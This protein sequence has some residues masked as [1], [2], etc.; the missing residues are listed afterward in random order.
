MNC[1]FDTNIL[2]YTLGPIDDPRR[3]AARDLIVR[4]MR[5]GNVV[6]TL[7]S[8]AEFSSVA[9]RKLGMGADAVQQR[10]Q[11]WSDVMPVQ[12]ATFDDLVAALRIVRDH[13]LSFWDALLCATILRAGVRYLFTE[14]LQDGQSLLG[15]TIVNP[16]AGENGRLADRILPP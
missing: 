16:L 6:L 4:G 14:D 2:V 3:Q 7:Q 1:S 10:V 13:R 9:T 11:A 15:M 12:P 5:N 8:L